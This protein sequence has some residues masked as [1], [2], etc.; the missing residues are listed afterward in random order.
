MTN[1]SGRDNN[2]L[3]NGRYQQ[4]DEREYRQHQG[5]G[6]VPQYQRWHFAHCQ[7]TGI[8]TRFMLLPPGFLDSLLHPLLYFTSTAPLHFCTSGCCAPV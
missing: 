8:T 7:R 5:Q 3:L 1:Q 4:E 6:R 2:P